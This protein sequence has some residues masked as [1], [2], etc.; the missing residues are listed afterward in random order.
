MERE[1]MICFYGRLINVKQLASQKTEDLFHI[2]TKL[3]N[4]WY[5][6]WMTSYISQ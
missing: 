4:S 3:G 6:T 5:A 2:S 1:S